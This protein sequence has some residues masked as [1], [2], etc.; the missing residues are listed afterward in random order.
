MAL[1]EKQLAQRR[2]ND[3]STHSLY[4]PGAS[5]TTIVREIIFCNTSGSGATFRLFLDDDGST[6][7]QTTALFYDMSVPAD[8]AY[9]IS[10]FFPM[11]N[12]SGNL[13]YSQNTANAFTITVFGVEIT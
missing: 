8:Q 11:N 4:S 2:D 6:Y 13:A 9:S 10:G 3:T 12:S 1:Q 7:D 5:T